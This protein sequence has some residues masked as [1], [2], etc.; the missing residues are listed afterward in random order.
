M[1]GSP[2][3]RGTSIHSYYLAELRALR[4]LVEAYGRVVLALMQTG[5]SAHDP[6]HR[7]AL[8]AAVAAHLAYE[9]AF[10]Q[11]HECQACG[12]TL[13]ANQF[14][15]QPSGLSVRCDA[16]ITAGKPTRTQAA[17]R[18][19]GWAG[20]GAWRQAHSAADYWI[21]GSGAVAGRKERA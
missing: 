18:A 9:A 3:T 10:A 14:R 12:H 7:P 1:S 17:A 4:A 11:P 2:P 6:A 16:C 20:I 13:P 5:G 21:S 19:V 8:D 15:R